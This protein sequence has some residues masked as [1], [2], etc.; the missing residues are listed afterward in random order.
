M[1]TSLLL[2]T[3]LLAGCAVPDT[4]PRLDRVLNLDLFSGFDRSIG[5]LQDVGK[6][7]DPPTR[8]SDAQAGDLTGQAALLRGRAEAIRAKLAH[9][10]DRRARFEHYQA[11]RRI[12]DELRPLERTL[13]NAGRP[14][15]PTTVQRAGAQKPNVSP[16]A[17]L[18]LQPN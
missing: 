9:E 18:N 10:N 3:I 6:R 1:R 12:G 17:H 4:S 14:S 5:A 7:P 8:L 11:L 16:F 13:E 2:A 15:R